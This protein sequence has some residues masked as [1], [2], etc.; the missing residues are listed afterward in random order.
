MSKNIKIYGRTLNFNNFDIEVYLNYWE[1]RSETWYI[2][3]DP[4]FVPE[5]EDLVRYNKFDLIKKLKN[6]ITIGLNRIYLN[7]DNMGYDPTYFATVNKFVVE[8][9][10]SE[11][12]Q[13]K[14]IKFIPYIYS[15]Y[16]RDKK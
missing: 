2:N 8:Q 11:I 1:I 4:R 10:S 14:S 6:E 12:E 15:K 16:F 13:T 9:F 7:Y 3:S 5:N